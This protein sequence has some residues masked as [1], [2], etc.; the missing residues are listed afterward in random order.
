M[1]YRQGMDYII[2]TLQFFVL[3]INHELEPQ[4]PNIWARR[5]R[6][7]LPV[8]TCLACVVE[9]PPPPSN[10][11]NVRRLMGCGVFTECLNSCS[12]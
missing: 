1:E 10:S 9:S 5:S 2:W 8:R 6:A 3:I 11:F 4:T 7:N 12:V